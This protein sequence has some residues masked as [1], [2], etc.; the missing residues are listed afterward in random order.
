MSMPSRSFSWEMVIRGH[1]IYKEIWTPMINEILVCSQEHK[2]SEDPLAVSVMKGDDIVGHVPR[3]VSRIIW[4][5]IAPPS[6]CEGF[7]P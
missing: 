2:N 7:L 4:Y 1:H 5:F 3:E 6:S